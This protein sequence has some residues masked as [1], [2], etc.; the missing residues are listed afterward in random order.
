MTDKQKIKH[1]IAVLEELCNRYE[2]ALNTSEARAILNNTKDLRT[3]LCKPHE[4]VG[5]D[6]KSFSPEAAGLAGKLFEC[7]RDRKDNYR[8]PN[9]AQWSLDM[10]K[11]L[12]LDKRTVEQVEELI[13]WSQQH[14]FW[15]HNILS[16]SKLRKQ[17]DRLEM[18]MSRDHQWKARRSLRRPKGK[19]AKDHYLE[20]LNETDMR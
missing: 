11:I 4:K 12:R 19:S 14:D 10:D 8:E 6:K 13:A 5:T 20:S 7:I 18:I 15:R 17:L 1:A 2:G 9:M 3:L 16:P